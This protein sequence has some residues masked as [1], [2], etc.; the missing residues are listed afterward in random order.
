VWTLLDVEPVFVHPRATDDHKLTYWCYVSY[1]LGGLT[2]L[3]ALLVGIPIWG[4]PALGLWG[5]PL[6][7]LYLGHALSLPQRSAFAHVGGLVLYALGAFLA[8]YTLSPLAFLANGVGIYLGWRA[9]PG[10]RQPEQLIAEFRDPESSTTVSA[11]LLGSGLVGGAILGSIIGALGAIL[12]AWISVE[13]MSVFGLLVLLPAV[14]AGIGVSLGVG[15][16]GGVVSGLVSAGLGIVSI[17]LGF[18]LISWWMPRGYR[19]EPGILLAVVPL[20]GVYLA[21]KL[22]TGL[23]PDDDQAADAEFPDDQVGSGE[24]SGSATD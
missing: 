16:H 22:G 3:A 6:G 17:G 5:L 2:I 4:F 18:R 15:E 7:A 24:Q 8:L 11:G 19:L 1:A 20:L 10:I 21:Y 9:T 12:F 13:T 14:G 23:S